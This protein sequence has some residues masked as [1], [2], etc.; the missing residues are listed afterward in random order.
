MSYSPQVSK[1]HYLAYSYDTKDRWISYWYQ[2]DAVM[3][4]APQKVL[5][6]GPGNRSV[7]DAL[8]KR[9]ISVTTFDIAKD[10]DPDFVGS[11]TQMPFGQNLFD[12]VLAAEVLEH[13]PH[14]DFPTALSEIFRVTKR[15]A[16][17]TLP[18]AG[19]VFSFGFKF[20]LSKY[21]NF[22][23]KLPF[24]WKIHDFNGEHYWE[25]GKRGYSVRRIK[26]EI[27][28]QGFSIRQARLRADDPA[29]YLFLLEK[30]N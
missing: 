9:G 24:F 2:F 29:H 16:I 15:F 10:L 6:V 28:R 4:L 27:V 11:V 3:Q 30:V 20:P 19:Y 23:W 8:K 18:H 5:E 7:T 17:I 1:K 25:L 13:L 12:V 22:I 21:I 14:K 26:K